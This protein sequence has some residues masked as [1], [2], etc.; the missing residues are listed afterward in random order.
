M[1]NKKINPLVPILD[2]VLQGRGFRRRKRT[3]YLETKETILVVDL[4][5]SDWSNDYF[6]NVG[7]LIRQLSKSWL[8][9]INECHII[10]RVE[11]LVCQK[12]RTKAEGHV[13]GK[14][15]QGEEIPWAIR[16]L[17]EKPDS[18]VTI[19][20]FQMDDVA[21][22]WLTANKDRILKALDLEDHTISGDER[23]STIRE[24][25]VSAGLPFLDKLDSVSKI[26]E[27]L[28][29]NRLSASAVRKTVYE[30]CGVAF[31]K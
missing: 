3:W 15:N 20:C 28:R 24:A 30:L 10:D 25:M 29:K 14:G 9:K 27:C 8:P 19:D 22:Q 26:G 2:D 5:K 17:S 6:I 7:V 21:R 31:G 13:E 16:R 23:A 11:V 1:S 12:D 4:Q 18:K